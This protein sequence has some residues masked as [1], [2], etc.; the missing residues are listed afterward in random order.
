MVFCGRQMALSDTQRDDIMVSAGFSGR[1]LAGCLHK[2][3]AAGMVKG[4]ITTSTLLCSHVRVLH[5]MMNGKDIGMLWQGNLQ[6]Y[7]RNMTGYG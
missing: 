6:N 5:S 1:C 7:Q 2:H 4:P 3:I